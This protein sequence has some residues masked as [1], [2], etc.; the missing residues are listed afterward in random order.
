VSD[1]NQRLEAWYHEVIR[2]LIL[3]NG[4]GA[5]AAST[6]LGSTF[7]HNHVL[8]A[9]VIPLAGFYLGLGVA[10]AVHLG[11]LTAAWMDRIGPGGGEYAAEQSWATRAGKWI[12]PRTGKF[13]IASFAC[14][15]FGGLSAVVVVL[16]AG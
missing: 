1:A 10:G 2:Y 16:C 15:C 13:V 9:G 5:V 12:E 14:F 7:A 4:G 11:Q 3:T 6:F 8:R